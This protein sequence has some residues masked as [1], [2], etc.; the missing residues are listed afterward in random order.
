MNAINFLAL[1]RATETKRTSLLDAIS[2][3]PL[4]GL[5][6]FDR[7]HCYPEFVERLRTDRHYGSFDMRLMRDRDEAEISKANYSRQDG[8][9]MDAGVVEIRNGVEMLIHIC[10]VPDTDNIAVLAFINEREKWHSMPNIILAKGRVDVHIQAEGR[11]MMPKFHFLI[12][13]YATVVV[14]AVQSLGEHLRIMAILS[15]S[16]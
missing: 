2:K 7:M 15:P 12:P 8:L 1:T 10:R 4:V 6:F 5:P 11:Q 9:M 16:A 13:H 3:G 14:S